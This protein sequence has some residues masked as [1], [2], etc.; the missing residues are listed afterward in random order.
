MPQ[1][2]SSSQV[3]Q[4]AAAANPNTV[5][6][7]PNGYKP[8]KT[9]IGFQTPDALVYHYTQ[10]EIATDFIVPKWTLKIGSITKTNDPK[11]TR[12]WK[13]TLGSRGNGNPSLLWKVFRHD[14]RLR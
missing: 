1:S 5:A 6:A 12:N 4:E 11:E 8:R 9:I 10:I 14:C 3:Q 13:F 7:I 2:H